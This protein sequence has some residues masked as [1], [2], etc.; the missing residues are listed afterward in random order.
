VADF[1]SSGGAIEPGDVTSRR[2]LIAGTVGVAALL[3]SGCSVENPTS[4]DKAPRSAARLAPDVTVAIRALAEIRAVRAAVSRTASRY[5]PVRPDLAPLV[6]MHRAHEA[7]LV[8][9]VPDRARPA[10]GPAPYVVPRKRA[11]AMRK[12]ATREQRLHDT[13]AG[14]SLKAESGDFARLLASMGAGINQ[15]LTVWPS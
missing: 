3:V 1:P 12:L 13:L 9:A 14:L 2:S 5:P 6:R 10:A 11:V 4:P 8:D 15:R 7:S